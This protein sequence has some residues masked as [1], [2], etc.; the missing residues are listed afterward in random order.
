LKL[1]LGL[2]LG[3]GK[4]TQEISEVLFD[5]VNSDRLT[6]LSQINLHKERL[7]GL[8]KFLDS[9]PQECSRHLTR[10]SDAGF[11]K[12]D[13]EGF[14]EIT[15]YGRAMLSMFPGIK[16]LAKYK[17]YFLSHD[18]TYLP[19]GFIAR[20]GELADG[21]YASNV[22]LVL[23]DIVRVISEAKEYVWLMADQPILTGSS[24]DRSLL[25]KNMPTR[26][27][28]DQAMPRESLVKLRSSLKEIFETGLISKVNFAM[29][30]N[31]EFAGICFPDLKGQV[32]FQSGFRGTDPEFHAWCTSLYLYFWE[33]SK[34]IIP[35]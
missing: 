27:I 11:I 18:L 32:D 24:I 10:L 5:L 13:S 31:E 15:S 20:I 7:M 26:L 17:D 12:K 16:F 1:E 6:L 14:F 4:L 19:H 23:G 29:A 25:A 22:S 3:G 30:I 33:I 9:T 2:N 28:A 21:Q 8:S 35:Y 34:R